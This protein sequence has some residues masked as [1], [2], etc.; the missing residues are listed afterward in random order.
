MDNG[1]Q[2]DIIE[3]LFRQRDQGVNVDAGKIFG[4]PLPD[5]QEVRDTERLMVY[6]RAH[7]SRRRHYRRS[8][9]A[10]KHR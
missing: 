10:T 5:S 7:E 9:V 6:K 3:E 1:K 8:I 4:P 2:I